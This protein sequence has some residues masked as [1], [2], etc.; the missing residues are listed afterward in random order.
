MRK[1]TLKFFSHWGPWMVIAYFGIV[2]VIVALFTLNSQTIKEDAAQAAASSRCIASRPTL[3]KF[4]DH[5][6][7]VNEFAHVLAVNSRNVLAQTPRDD[8]QYAVRQANLA[9][10]LKANRK[11]AA[12][13]TF[14]VPS[15]A[16]C[17]AVKP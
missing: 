9:R 10:I 6:Q 3:L 15:V 8:P 13:P 4:R 7:G 11:I 1:R 12:L 5:I 16:E 17:N 2:A 14:H